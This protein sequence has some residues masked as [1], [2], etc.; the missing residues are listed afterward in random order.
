MFP[1]LV[2]L[3]RKVQRSKL[4]VICIVILACYFIVIFIIPE[5]YA[6]ALFY[7]NPCLRIIDFMIGVGIFHL[8]K[9]IQTNKERNR[10]FI[11]LQNTSMA[12]IIEI[13]VLLLLILMVLI[14]GNIPQRFRYASYYWIPMALVVLWFA[15]TPRG[16]G[17]GEITRYF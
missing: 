11:F 1:V 13:I 5:K 6:H 3:L 17:G 9:K 4:I 12:T 10:I 7:I 15:G 16:G 14:S 8:W 2:L